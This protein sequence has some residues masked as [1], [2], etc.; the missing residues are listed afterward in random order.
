MKNENG[1]GSVYKLKNKKKNQWTACV[2]LGWVQI[3]DNSGTPVRA[4]QKRIRIGYYPTRKDAQ[5]AL[6]KWHE[7]HQQN[8][9][10][11]TKTPF[12]AS[13]VVQ[14]E[15]YTPTLKQ[16]RNSRKMSLE[17]GIT[18]TTQ[19]THAS[20]FK[21][22]EPLHDKR[23]DEIG[24]RELQALF[25]GYSDKYKEGTL[26]ALKAFLSLLFGEAVK[27]GYIPA[28]LSSI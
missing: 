6:A 13:S 18:L 25:D 19:K 4:K 1:F 17:K 10:Q 5:L 2:T 9:V 26:S 12:L 15:N 3:Y 27:L 23:I 8:T 11:A 22:L 16:L 20:F 14:L 24:Y 21:L 7:E 28:S